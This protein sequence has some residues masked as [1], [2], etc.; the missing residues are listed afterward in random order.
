VIVT[1]AFTAAVEFLR[2]DIEPL[3]K[4]HSFNASRDHRNALFKFSGGFPLFDTG[5]E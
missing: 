4:S 2:F 5:S 1:R 3:A